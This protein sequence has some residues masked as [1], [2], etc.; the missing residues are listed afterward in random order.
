MIGQKKK[1]ERQGFEITKVETLVYTLL[2]HYQATGETIYSSDPLTYGRCSVGEEL[3]E[4]GGFRPFGFFG[5]T[6][7][8]DAYHHVGVGGERKF[9]ETIGSWKLES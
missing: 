5:D 2:W 8:D 9:I 3:V 4:V 7:F 1:K 6:H